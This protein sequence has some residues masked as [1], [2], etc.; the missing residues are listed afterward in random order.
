[1]SSL[2]VPYLT[3]VYVT[4]AAGQPKEG[5]EARRETVDACLQ[6]SGV[7][8]SASEGFVPTVPPSRL[9]MQVS[10]YAVW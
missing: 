2:D 6:T 3:P 10:S 7:F 8:A 1:M 9:I 4:G 5:E